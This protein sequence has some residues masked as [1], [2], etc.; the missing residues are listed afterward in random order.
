MLCVPV[1]CQK[2]FLCVPVLHYVLVRKSISA[3]PLDLQKLMQ[4]ETARAHESRASC[5]AQGNILIYF[6][7]YI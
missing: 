2:V 7:Y 6:T 3:E 5:A 1:K 4:T